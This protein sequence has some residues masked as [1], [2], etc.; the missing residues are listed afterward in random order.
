MDLVFYLL[1]L[2]FSLFFLVYT[3]MKR[4]F[5]NS[6]KAKAR[7][8]APE[9][10]P[11]P[12]P[13][14]KEVGPPL[15]FPIGKVEKVD[16]TLP[17]GYD[18]KNDI[19][20]KEMDPRGPSDPNAMLY[21]TLPI[22]ADEDEPVSECFFYPGTKE[23]FTSIPGFPRPMK[24]PTRRTFRT[25]A[26]PGKGMGLVSARKL[27]AGDLILSERPLMVCGRAMNIP[28]PPSFSRAQLMQYTLNQAEKQ[29]EIPVKRMRPAA[30][31][32]F[33]AL[34][35][36]HKEDGSGPIMGIVRTNG[37]LIPGLRPGV[38]DES[39]EYGAVC[40]D[41]SRLNHSCSPNTAPRFDKA[42]FSFRLYAVR[43]IPAGEELTFQYILVEQ[44]TAKR[45]E[46]LKPYAF[47][48]TCR[49]CK[50]PTSDGRREATTTFSKF[51]QQ[52]V[53]TALLE[54][55]FLLTSLMLIVYEGLEHFPVYYDAL[56]MLME[57]C[58]A[59]G[60]A[61]KASEWAAKLEKCYWDESREEEQDLTALLDP[62][63]SAYQK[64]PMWRMLLDGKRPDHP[65]NM[66]E[67]VEAVGKEGAEK[68]FERQTRKG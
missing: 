10:P 2:T 68:L 44:P 39:S 37:L 58:I 56:K 21:T 16:V 47:R 31:A 26:M 52:C 13:P 63:S 54:E 6:T 18:S 50:D 45:Q 38:E 14:T 65:R 12:V 8:L 23:V 19:Q 7:P 67:L 30:K 11:A 33:M 60:D 1:P 17:E 49:A 35:N 20:Y 28:A 40:K 24:H 34:A 41:I 4:G 5:L 27:K 59:R 25:V 55:K 62:K 48:C 32:A 15:R 43:D 42:S 29:H 36:S 9:V 51:S 46:E 53:G 66:S 22:G 61:Q 57:G 64:H 3:S